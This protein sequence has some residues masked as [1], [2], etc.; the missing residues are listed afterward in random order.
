MS[1]IKAKLNFNQLKLTSVRVKHLRN[2]RTG[3][4]GSKGATNLG[5]LIEILTGANIPRKELEEK[6]SLSPSLYRHLLPPRPES[7]PEP[8]L[9][10]LLV[11]LQY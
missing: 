4:L 1:L 8:G 9:N 6:L 7:S 3:R 2:Q 10:F 5:R 11:V